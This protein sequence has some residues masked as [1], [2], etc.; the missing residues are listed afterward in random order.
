MNSKLSVLQ[1]LGHLSFCA[2]VLDAKTDIV[3]VAIVEHDHARG[4]QERQDAAEVGEHLDAQGRKRKRK[5][6][7]EA[8]TSRMIL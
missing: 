8:G 7:F 4:C 1:E 3:L 5:H 6:G 2:R